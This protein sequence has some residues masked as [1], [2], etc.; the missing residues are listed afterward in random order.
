[1]NIL[2]QNNSSDK[3]Y[4]SDFLFSLPLGKQSIQKSI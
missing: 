3:R 2:L 4:F 1:M